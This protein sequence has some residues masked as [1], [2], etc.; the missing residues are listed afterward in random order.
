MKTFWH[1]SR[2][3]F[4]YGALMAA[5]VLLLKW[6]E[7]KFFIA[8]NSIEIYIGLIALFFL[9]FGVWIA[10]QF[11]IQKTKTVIVEKEVI[12]EVS[13]LQIDQTALENLQLTNRE[14]EVL[15]QIVQ[16]NSNAQIAANLFL[17]LSTVKTHAS[18]LYAKLDVKSR[19]QAIE[20]AKRLKIIV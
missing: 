9:V 12:R 17:S 7:W 20:K 18:N 16:G 11:F 5:L 10:R 19:T 13:N 8:D 6:L 14:Y 2:Y 1:K 4:L 3:L 15:D